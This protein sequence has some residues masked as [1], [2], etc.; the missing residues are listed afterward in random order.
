MPKL[1]RTQNR[2]SHSL[3]SLGFAFIVISQALSRHPWLLD[4]RF[5]RDSKAAVSLRF[6]NSPSHFLPWW[7]EFGKSHFAALRDLRLSSMVDL[8]L[9]GQGEKRTLSRGERSHRNTDAVPVQAELGLWVFGPIGW[10]GPVSGP[11]A[12]DL[13]NQYGSWP[14]PLSIFSRVRSWLVVIASYFSVSIFL[15]QVIRK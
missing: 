10:V 9:I 15:F 13:Y 2:I 7:K 6:R 8:D 3:V 14:F 12:A 5:I 1:G 11:V 4:A